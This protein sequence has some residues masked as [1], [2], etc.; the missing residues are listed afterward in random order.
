MKFKYQ[1]HVISGEIVSTH[2]SSDDERYFVKVVEPVPEE[3]QC[4]T[5]S[6]NLWP[7]EGS[8]L[9]AEGVIND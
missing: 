9:L 1:G 5:R 4:S 2:I 8:I 3:I 7:I 6:G